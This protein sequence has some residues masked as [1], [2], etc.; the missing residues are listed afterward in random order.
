MLSREQQREMLAVGLLALALFT[1]LALV[2]ISLLGERGAEWFPSGNALGVV[3][4]VIDALLTAFLGA[5]AFLV[6]MNDGAAR[7]ATR[8]ATT[9]AGCGAGQRAHRPGRDTHL[10]ARAASRACE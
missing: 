1:L 4:G 10:R 6:P 9:A 2:P 7:V 8:M 3:G 5:A